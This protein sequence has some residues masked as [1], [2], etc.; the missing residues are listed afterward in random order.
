[1][2]EPRAPPRL[3]EAITVLQFDGRPIDV[4]EVS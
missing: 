4:N 1:M 2:R 3:V